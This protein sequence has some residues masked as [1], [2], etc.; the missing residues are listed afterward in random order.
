[1]TL[2]L[3]EM[4]PGTAEL[5][6]A[7]VAALPTPLEPL[8]LP[9]I[10][11]RASSLH[12][13][14]DDLTSTRYGGNK[15][16][17]LD[18]LLGDAVGQGRTTV[19]TFGAYGSNHALATAVHA[20]A[21]GLEP[22]VVL[23]PQAPGPFAARTLLAHA[24]LGTKVHLVDGWDGRREA[25]RAKQAIAARDGLEPYVIPMGGTNALGALGY[26]N[27]GLEVADSLDAVY[28]AA[29]TL[30]TAVGLAVGLA[31][32]GSSARVEAIRVTPAEI[33]TV[34]IAEQ[35]TAETIALLRSLDGG[36]PALTYDELHMTLRDEFFE[37]GYGVVTPETTAAVEAAASAGLHLETTYTG[38][39][40]SAMSVDAA[41]GRLADSRVLFWDT[42]NSAPYPEAG[43][44]EALPQALQE[45]IA[46][47]ERLFGTA[48]PDL[49]EGDTE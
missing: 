32:A 25:V 35:L 37:P 33:C 21:L 10:R 43:P 47:C 40:F 16:R 22:H 23:S 24:G 19:L 17:K 20:R 9:E 6:L 12:V 39:A 30:G 2:P 7:G 29:G 8:D 34:A 28:V 38:K 49:S 27:A 1:M 15:V 36:V 44:V 26:V 11:A 5:P 31:L 13:K 41:A 42:Y 46:E 48:T 14:R 4:F 45:Y 18:F 3:F